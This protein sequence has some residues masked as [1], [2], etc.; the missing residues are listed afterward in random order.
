[1]RR[2]PARRQAADPGLLRQQGHAAVRIV[3]VLDARR[4]A[5]T[6][7][8]AFEAALGAQLVEVAPD[9]LDGDAELCRQSLDGDEAPLAHGRHDGAAPPLDTGRLDPVL[10][11]PVERS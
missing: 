1:M 6:A 9:R 10:G 3:D 4:Q 2:D 11:S 8:V 7:P 5:A